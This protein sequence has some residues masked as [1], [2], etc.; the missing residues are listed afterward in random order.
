[1]ET[2]VFV[3]YYGGGIMKTPVLMSYSRKGHEDA[4]CIDL[5]QQRKTRRHQSPRV[6]TVEGG[7]KT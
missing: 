3:S 2:P 5:F 4:S 7:T 1:M 6:S